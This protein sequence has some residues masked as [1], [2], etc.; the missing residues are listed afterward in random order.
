MI[1][2]FI[3]AIALVLILIGYWLF[4]QKHCY[5]HHTAI[6]HS[7]AKSLFA[8]FNQLEHWSQWLP[9]DLYDDNSSASVNYH[10]H[11][12]LEQSLIQLKGPSI[13]LITCHIQSCQAPEHLA[14][15]IAS[16]GYYPCPI[17]VKFELSTNKEDQLL[18]HAVGEAELSF[19]QRLQYQSLLQQLA[20][21][22][23]LMMVRLK[24]QVEEQSVARMQFEHL[25]VS[26]LANIDAV[27][28]PFIV[29][30][31]P[32][33]QKMEQGFRDLAM[34]L[35]PEN[36]P[37]GP[38][39]ALYEAA[40]LQ[41]HY[42]TGKLGIT[43]QGLSPCEAEPERLCFRGQYIALRYQGS[44]H[45]LGLAW[46]VLKRYS[47]LKG[48]KHA[49]ARNTLEMFIVSPRDTDNETELITILYLP[50]Q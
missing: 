35:G 5:V 17:L 48:H 23:R 32:M 24:A 2:G 6:L 15:E 11:N 46:H 8:E 3:I 37:A 10:S 36:K 21:D 22:V 14:F 25:E 20:A 34:T 50:I 49:R 42:F 1:I 40:D 19:W 45:H 41:R 28:R 29:S 16:D 39:F 33:S 47:T 43:I 27:T 31:Q 12:H 13:G 44:Y 7:D 38:S 4:T 30:E 18:L 26:S 9:W